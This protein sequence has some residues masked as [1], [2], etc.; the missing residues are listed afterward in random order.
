MLVSDMAE[1]VD[2]GMPT[3]LAISKYVHTSYN[4][5]AISVLSMCLKYNKLNSSIKDRFGYAMLKLLNLH[6]SRLCR[7][8]KA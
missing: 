7:T 2:M 5:E 4:F 1:V 8:H 3:T 6:K